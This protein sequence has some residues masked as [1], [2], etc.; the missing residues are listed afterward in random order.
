MM[1]ALKHLIRHTTHGIIAFVALLVPITAVAQET[2]P[3]VF[4]K[5][6]DKVD[7]SIEK[8]LN[9]LDGILLEEY[10]GYVHP[11]FSL[12]GAVSYRSA[13]SRPTRNF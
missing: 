8:A 5:Y 11:G 10:G 7:P 4:A 6:K 12:N 13:S 3:T 2:T 1:L 9:Y